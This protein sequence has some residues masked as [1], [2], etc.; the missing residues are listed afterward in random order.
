[1]NDI[2]KTVLFSLICVLTL[3]TYGA[4]KLHM[5]E[6]TQRCEYIA[7]HSDT[8]YF[9]S[10]GWCMIEYKKGKYIPLKHFKGVE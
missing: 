10:D 8:N 4:Y 9:V 5:L 1:M 6:K 3:L 7:K 2:D